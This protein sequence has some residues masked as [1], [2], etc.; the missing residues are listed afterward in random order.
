MGPGLR[1]RPQVAL[2]WDAGVAVG[3]QLFGAG[4]YEVAG[5]ANWD[6]SDWY[7][8]GGGLLADTTGGAY[9]ADVR[10]LAMYGDLLVAAGDIA[11]VGNVVSKGIAFWDGV[12]WR[13]FAQGEPDGVRPQRI[14]MLAATGARLWA[15]GL[16]LVGREDARTC[17]C[18]WDGRSW[19][20]SSYVPRIADI[21]A[22]ADGSLWIAASRPEALLPGAMRYD[23]LRLAPEDAPRLIG[24]PSILSIDALGPIPARGSLDVR[25]SLTRNAP[26]R[27]GLYNVGG[28]RIVEIDGGVQAAGPHAIHID[29]ESLSLPLILSGVYFLRIEAGDDVVSR[30]IVVVR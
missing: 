4:N 22:T 12:A 28:R 7:P 18:S 19:R 3:G 23:L 13:A 6:G 5:V 2:A 25:Y 11:F 16:F 24:R 20:L 29:A 21:C 26:L 27:Y 8:L 9:S 14:D 10:D 15:F 1:G 30:R 17:L